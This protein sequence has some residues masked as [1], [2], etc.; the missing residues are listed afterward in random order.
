[1]VK[2]RLQRVGLKRQPSYRIT[3]IDGRK[4]NNAKVLEKIGYHNP[5]TQPETNV[6]DDERAFYWLS[7]GAQPTNAVRRIFEATGTWDRFQRLR[8]GEDLEALVEEAKQQQAEAEVP[9]A[10]TAHPAPGPGESKIKA[11][12]TLLE[13]EEE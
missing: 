9:S 8:Q 2:I 10:K 1:M 6:V 5:R 13:G 12:E 7:V 11:R 3:V 4:A